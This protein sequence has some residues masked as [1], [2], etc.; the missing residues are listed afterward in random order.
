MIFHICVENINPLFLVLNIHYCEPRKLTL[1]KI[2]N[3][4]QNYIGPQ[5][6]V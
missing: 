1:T 6:Q 3:V 5:Y 2:I 4:W